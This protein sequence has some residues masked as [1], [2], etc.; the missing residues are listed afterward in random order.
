MSS[1]KKTKSASKKKSKSKKG[2]CNFSESDEAID[3]DD[4]AEELEALLT[5]DQVY[6]YKERRFN[7]SNQKEWIKKHMLYGTFL[8]INKLLC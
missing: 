3:E 8:A 5:A 7:F 4:A 2:K 1:A 6:R